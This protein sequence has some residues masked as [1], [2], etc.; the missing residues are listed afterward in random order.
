MNSISARDSL[1]GRCL[2]CPDGSNPCASQSANSLQKSSRQQYSAVISI[3]IEGLSRPGFDAQCSQ[4]DAV[5]ALVSWEPPQ[6]LSIVR[7]NK[8]PGGAII[9]TRVSLVSSC[10]GGR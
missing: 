7:V 5:K 1:P 8:P 4:A 6:P 9:V 10:A 2:V 3:A